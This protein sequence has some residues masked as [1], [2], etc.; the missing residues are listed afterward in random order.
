MK[1]C[2]CF[3]GIAAALLAGFP[4]T[5]WAHSPIPL[6][7]FYDGVFETLLQLAMFLPLLGLI[8]Y[9]TGRGRAFARA[10]AVAVI[11]A[12][13]AGA[14]ISLTGVLPSPA[15]WPALILAAL[16]GLAAAAHVALP[17]WAGI[18]LGIL[19]GVVVGSIGVAGTRASWLFAVG[20]FAAVGFL[21]VVLAGLLVERRPQWIAIGLRIV[22]SWIAAIS[23]LR[24]ALL[25]A[26]GK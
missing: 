16:L 22:G 5:L 9:A 1:H 6:N 13:A 20:I 21:V 14:G 2:R 15:I 26:V 23:M 18:L 25:F 17:R 4:G 12:S 10:T 8:V 11:T 7:A 19:V 3:I 24:L